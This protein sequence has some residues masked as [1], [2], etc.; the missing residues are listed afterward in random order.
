M[1]LPTLRELELE[2]LLRERDNQV[3][4]LTVGRYAVSAEIL[5]SD[6]VQCVFVL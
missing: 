3:T 2:T 1:E 4:E 6:A 5:C